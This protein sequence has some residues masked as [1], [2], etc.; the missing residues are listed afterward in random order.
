[1]LID[2]ADG[3]VVA[4][5]SH[6]RFGVTLYTGDDEMC[7]SITNLA[8]Q[9]DASDEIETLFD[10]SGP[11]AETPTGESLQLATAFLLAD[12]WEGEKVRVLATDGELDTCDNPGPMEGEELDAV[13][14]LAV[15]AVSDAFDAGFRTSVISEGDEVGERHLQELA[16]AGVGQDSSGTASFYTALDS[17]SLAESFEEIIAGVRSCALDLEGTLPSRL[18]PSCTVTVNG[19]ELAYEGPDGWILEDEET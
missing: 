6:V 19:S 7:P 3:V 16:N 8:P 13:W 1:T 10:A 11:E 9:L 17:A 5:Q 12:T 14:A 18:A 2:P 15:R 4:L